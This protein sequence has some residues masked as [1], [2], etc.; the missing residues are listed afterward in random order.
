ML[1]L[2]YENVSVNFKPEYVYS[3]DEGI[4]MLGQVERKVAIKSTQKEHF[5]F[6]WENHVFSWLS[7]MF[8]Y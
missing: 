8:S 6:P 2:K 4:C 3:R 7:K 1:S 5:F